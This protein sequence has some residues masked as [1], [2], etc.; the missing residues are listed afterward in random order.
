MKGQKSRSGGK[1]RRGF[2]GGTLPMM[3]ALPM[4]KGFTNIFRVEYQEVNLERLGSFPPG[5]IVTPE[6]LKDHGIIKSSNK[7]VKILG[8][9]ELGNS[10]RVIAHKFSRSAKAGIES[11]G[12]STESL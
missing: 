8:R 11:V 2:A 3:K 1:L 9:G 7:R 10:I 6:V 12:G 4:L 5:A